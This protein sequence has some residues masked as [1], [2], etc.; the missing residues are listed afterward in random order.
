MISG[1]LTAESGVRSFPLPF[2]L[3]LTPVVA[4]SIVVFV[5]PNT[6]KFAMS[7][8]VLWPGLAKTVHEPGVH[9]FFGTGDPGFE[10]VNDIAVGEDH[11]GLSYPLPQ[12]EKGRID[13]ARSSFRAVL[14]GFY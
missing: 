6:A 7:R 4:V 3:D 1:T 13:D 10:R 9:C 2:R 11:D 8:R 12:L 14:V 5:R